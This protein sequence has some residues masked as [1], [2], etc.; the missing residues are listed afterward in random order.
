MKMFKCSYGPRH[1]KQ[2]VYDTLPRALV[3]PAHWIV[4]LELNEVEKRLSLR[5]PCFRMLENKMSQAARVNDSRSFGE[6]MF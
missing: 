3:I 5:W 4:I 2:L 6:I 1:L